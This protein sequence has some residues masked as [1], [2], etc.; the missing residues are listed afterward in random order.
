MYLAAF[1]APNG[2]TVIPLAICDVDSLIL[3]N[4]DIDSDGG[5]DMLRQAAFREALYA[6]CSDEDV[7]LATLLLAPEPSG[8]TNTPLVTTDERYGRIP[9]VY[10]ELKQDRA[11]TPALQRRMIEAMP[12]RE[13]VALDAS[14]SAYF[15]K[16]DELTEALIALGERHA[17]PLAGFTGARVG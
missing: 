7:A 5:F 14:H 3:R 6:D 9:R 11:V 4:L 16:P 1:L 2:E 8:P 12:C 13:T 17:L 15:S 10:I